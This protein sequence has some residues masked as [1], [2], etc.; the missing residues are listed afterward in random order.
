LATDSAP[1][2]LAPGPSVRPGEVLRRS[3]HPPLK[4]P[5]FWVIQGAVGFLTALH[6]GLDAAGAFHG[7]AALRTLPVA[8]LVAPVGYAALRYGLHGS[9]ATAAWATILWL[10]VLALHPL[11][12]DRGD[13]LVCLLLVDS[14]GLFVGHRV[15][16]Q[17]LL[18]QAARRAE[19]SLQASEGRYRHLFAATRAPIIVLDAEGRVIDANPAAFAAF[20]S[21]VL[22]ARASE[23]LATTDEE[24]LSGAHS[25]RVQLRIEGQQVEFRYVATPLGSPEVL[26]R[27]VVQVMLQD[28]TA[29]RRALRDVRE[30]ADALIGAQER[31]RARLAREIHDDPLQR[32]VYLA[33]SL[34]LVGFGEEAPEVCAARVEE[35]RVAAI[36]AAKRLRDIARGLRPPALDQLGLAAAI[37]GLAAESEEATGVRV[38]VS[39]SGEERRLAPEAELG[40]FRIAQEAVNNALGHAEPSRV[41]LR[42]SYEAGWVVLSVADDG[43][44]IE[45]GSLEDLSHLGIR[46]M[47]E[48]AVLLGG[49]LELKSTP[50]EGTVVTASVPALDAPRTS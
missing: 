14:V 42:L 31:E 49:T 34:E 43:S 6:I 50:G 13:E 35:A 1:T 21:G 24:L 29:E 23:L 36:D 15:E 45:P 25:G 5:P 18:E 38:E 9:A 33:R 44:G 3:F 46:G 48:R 8:A 28:V 37:E 32:L 11:A 20:G 2:K 27:E 17:A 22:D 4:D 12:A 19:S 16:R 41:S 30:Y 10:P 39:V 47:R 7:V 26:G 40:L